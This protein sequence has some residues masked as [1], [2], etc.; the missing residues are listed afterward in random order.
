[1]PLL[2][3]VA[4]TYV[5]MLV[6]VAAAVPQDFVKYATGLVF[7]V[8]L[9]LSLIY[10]AQSFRSLEKVLATI[11]AIGL[12]LTLQGFEQ[13]MSPLECMTV[14]N[15]TETDAAGIPDGR[16]CQD[17]R[18]CYVGGEPGS[19]YQCEKAGW[20]GT[21]SI[22]GGRVRYRGFLQDPN[23][24][25]TAIASALPLA[26]M[27][28]GR[29]RAWWRILLAAALTALVLVVTVFTGS[30]TGQLVVLV[31]MTV[32]YAPRLGWKSILIG[33]LMA[34]PVLLFGGRGGEEASESTMERL[35]AWSTGIDLFRSSPIWGIGVDQFS[36]NHY[37]TAH[38]TLVLV[39]AEMGIVGLVVWL[40]MLYMCF[41]IMVTA[42][43]R[44]RTDP[45]GELA[46]Q[47][48]RA[49]F[50]SL[51]VVFVA[52]QFLSL[53]YHFVVWVF[54]GVSGAFYMS[55]RRHDPDFRVRFGLRDFFGVTIFSG[56]YVVAV[57]VYCRLRGV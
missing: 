41:K 13:G 27:F 48:A 51:S 38:N 12:F 16:P 3:L 40:S 23:E 52:G 56:L 44:Y 8:L 57:F 28:L 49:I 6:S 55:V 33:A 46:H 50:S 25:A 22:G 11:A 31:V 17:N 24:L 53:A 4:A 29:R 20:L 32:L 9:V 30:R 37:L 35:E 2:F 39:V 19:E 10:G 26:L 1:M 15:S 36:R 5:W 21:T 54:F 43:I 34:G 45:E 14:E 7:Q 18:E 42:L 47:W